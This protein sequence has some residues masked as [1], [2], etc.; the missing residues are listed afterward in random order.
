[1]SKGWIV[2]KNRCRTIQICVLSLC[3]G[4]TKLICVPIYYDGGNKDKARHTI[5]LSLKYTIPD[6]PLRSDTQGV[7][8][9]MMDLTFI[10]PNL[11][12][13]L[14]VSINQPVANKECPFIPSNFTLAYANHTL[15]EWQDDYNWCRPHSGLGN[16]TPLEFSQRKAMD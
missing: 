1:M 4:L 10:Q 7:F 16:L 11:R 13:S 15:E 3:N 9:C 14:H 2:H 5:M 6:F 8:K 12:T